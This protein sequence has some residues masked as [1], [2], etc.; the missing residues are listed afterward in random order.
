MARNFEEVFKQALSELEA[1]AKA[2]GT[3]LTAIC[4]ETKISRTTPDRWR[5]RPPATVR[6]IAQLQQAV[7]RKKAEHDALH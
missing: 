3:S 4:R 1:D 2:A 6:L 5:A 7:E